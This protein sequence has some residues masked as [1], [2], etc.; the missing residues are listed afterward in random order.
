MTQ[1]AAGRTRD[2]RRGPA[3]HPLAWVVWLLATVAALL[4]TRNPVYLADHPPLHRRHAAR[5]AR[6]GLSHLRCPCP[7]GV[8]G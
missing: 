1:R 2:T 4:T 6:A 3:I 8:S 7:Y 5:R